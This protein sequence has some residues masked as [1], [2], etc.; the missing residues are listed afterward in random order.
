MLGTVRVQKVEARI[1]K[2]LQEGRLVPFH[3]KPRVE[4]AGTRGRASRHRTLV[5]SMLLVASC[6]RV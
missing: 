4:R 2:I 1:T 3:V 6:E 5:A